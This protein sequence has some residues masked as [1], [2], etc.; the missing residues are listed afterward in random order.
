VSGKNIFLVVCLLW[1]ERSHFDFNA[2]FALSAVSVK[3]FLAIA[4]F[5]LG[6]D[7]KYDYAP[8]NLVKSRQDAYYYNSYWR[9]LMNRRERRGRR[10]K[11]KR[12]KRS[13]EIKLDLELHSL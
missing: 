2:S 9:G 8:K 3:D 10:G 4:N 7:V 12:V 1:V 11:S 5:E 13:K 6:F